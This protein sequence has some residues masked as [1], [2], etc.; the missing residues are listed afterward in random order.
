MNGSL[1]VPV[2]KKQ[3]KYAIKKIFKTTNIVII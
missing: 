3:Y 2:N 1:K